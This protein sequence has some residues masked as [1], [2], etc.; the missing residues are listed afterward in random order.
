MRKSGAITLANPKFD[1]GIYG[2]L[3]KFA[4]DFNVKTIYV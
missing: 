2:M 4:A 1:S 3:W